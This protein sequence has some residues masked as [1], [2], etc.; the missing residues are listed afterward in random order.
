[1]WESSCKYHVRNEENVSSRHH[2]IFQDV[3]PVIPLYHR[4]PLECV[5]RAIN[6]Y[7]WKL[8]IR[9]ESKSLHRVSIANITKYHGAGP[10]KQSG[11]IRKYLSFSRAK[12]GRVAFV[13]EARFYSRICTS[14][15]ALTI[16]S[17]SAV[18]ENRVNIYWRSGGGYKPLFVYGYSRP[19]PLKLRSRAEEETRSIDRFSSLYTASQL[20]VH[21]VI[22]SIDIM[23]KRVFFFFHD[24]IT[25]SNA[26][27]TNTV[28]KMIEAHE[29]NES[30][31]IW[32][33]KYIWFIPNLCQ[34][35]N[36]E[37]ITTNN[38]LLYLYV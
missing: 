4:D 36:F 27:N 37:R 32:D 5:G 3:T 12:W 30:E 31:K 7:R 38:W 35:C 24:K 15:L 25:S 29:Y 19:G 10:V 1:M 28:A 34:I 2:F 8:H 26:L 9:N 23:D 22:H 14:I 6:M 11:Y 21:T 18:D 20:L 16:T 13:R 17:V 33:G